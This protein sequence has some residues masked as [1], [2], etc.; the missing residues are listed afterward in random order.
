MYVMHKPG[1]LNTSTSFEHFSY[2]MT[3]AAIPFTQSDFQMQKFQE[4]I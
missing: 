4:K 3:F 2:I 1:W